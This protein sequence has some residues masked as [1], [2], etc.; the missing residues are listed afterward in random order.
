MY[1]LPPREG[2]K[3]R[4]RRWLRQIAKAEG[5]EGPAEDEEDQTPRLEKRGWSYVAVGDW[6][7]Y[8]SVNDRPDPNAE[9]MVDPKLLANF[10]FV[11]K[12]ARKRKLSEWDSR[13]LHIVFRVGHYSRIRS[14]FY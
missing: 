9:Y 2:Y 12:T 11:E 10:Q 14:A 4:I 7:S 8:P 3:L 1:N 13:R 6:A 5:R